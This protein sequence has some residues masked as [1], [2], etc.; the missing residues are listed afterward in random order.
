MAT[1]RREKAQ[2]EKPNPDFNHGCTPMDT[3]CG[4]TKP[5][6]QKTFKPQISRIVADGV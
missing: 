2:K 6:F 1:K 4:D 5:I 3:D